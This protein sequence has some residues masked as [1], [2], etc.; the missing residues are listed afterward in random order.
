MH[1][2]SSLAAFRRNL[3]RRGKVERDLAEEVDSYLA[4]STDAKVRDGLDE[5]AARRAATVEL[6]GV[7]QVKEQVREVRAGHFL[8]TRWQDLRFAFR[9]LRKSPVFSGT[10]VLVLALG[11]GSTALMFTIVNSLL[12]R[13]PAFPEADR[14]YMLWQQIPQE[15]RVSFSPNEFAAWKKQ[16]EVF[17]HLAIFAGSGFTISGQGEPEMV[18]G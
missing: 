7:E 16:T 3:F 5:A 8:E 10:V 1:I 18:F 6:G 15:D 11:I 2:F 9:T 17:E 12:L 13:G 4:L 14:L